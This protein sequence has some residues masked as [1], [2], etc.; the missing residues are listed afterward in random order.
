MQR[1]FRQLDS[2]GF[3]GNKSFMYG[4]STSNQRI[5][6]WWGRLFKDMRDSGIYQDD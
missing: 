2:D 3:S 6:A 4:R 1:F 5:E